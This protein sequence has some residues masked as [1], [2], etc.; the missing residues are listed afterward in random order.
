MFTVQKNATKLT[1][2][3][4]PIGI[5]L[6]SGLAIAFGLG[7]VLSTL[8][9]YE[10]T[11]KKSSLSPGTAT[12]HVKGS[13]WGF[14][15]NEKRVEQVRALRVEKAYN[16]DSEQTT[17]THSFLT[18]QG[19]EEVH[20]VYTRGEQYHNSVVS[21]FALWMKQGSAPFGFSKISEKSQ[22][23]MAWLPVLIGL[24]VFIFLARIILVRLDRDKEECIISS[25][26]L[27]GNKTET[28]PL[29]SVNSAFVDVS[30]D[31]D[32]DETYRIV[33]QQWGTNVPLTQSY[34]S[35]KWG[36]ERA[37]NAINDFLAK[38]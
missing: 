1:L 2:L 19:A 16:E 34:S 28:L 15:L 31:S 10:V 33:I 30:T 26:G 24:G 7:T 29:H 8:S 5:T 4:I 27:S 32:G 22:A 35:G 17:Y 9:T 18:P 38:R 13:I 37:A 23:G 20:G 25:F 11:C 12:C 3:H 14:Q 21:N 36:K 6:I